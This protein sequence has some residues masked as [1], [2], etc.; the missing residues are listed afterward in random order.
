MDITLIII[1]IILF[2]LSAF[3]SGTEIALMSLPSHK[4][5]ALL[6]EWK[7]WSKALRSIKKNNDRLLI[8]IL[9][10]NN[11]VN[12]YT[13]ALATT[14]AISIWQTIN[15]PQATAVWVATWIVTSNCFFPIGY[16]LNFIYK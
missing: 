2:S 13:A 8:T 14:I 10:W 15:L 3:F 9:I 5:E 1:F 6:K 12:V 16:I 7:F 11:L 4:L